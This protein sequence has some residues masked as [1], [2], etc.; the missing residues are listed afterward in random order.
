MKVWKDI[1]SG[2]E[3][4]SDSYKYEEIMD[5]HCL[6]VQGKLITKRSD[7]I[8]IASDE[9]DE[10]GGD[11]PQVI[12]IVEAHRLQEVHNVDKKAWMGMIKV[13]LKK[14]KDK[15]TELGKT[16][17]EIKAFMKGATE[18]VK[19]IG[20]KFDEFQLF[21]GESIDMEASMAY[22]IYDEEAGGPKF[23]F[24]LDGLKE[25]KF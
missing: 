4:V 20:S 9:E 2:D 3:M 7:N 24:F 17:E 12:D 1:L 21:T 8:K 22:A 18:L 6:T 19:F 23:Y 5:G 16:E 13:F 15:L 14:C 11:G 10:M 25:E